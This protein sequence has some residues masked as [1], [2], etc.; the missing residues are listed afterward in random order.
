[1]VGGLAFSQRVTL[2][3]TP[4]FYTYVDALQRRLG[5][6]RVP[7]VAPAAAPVPAD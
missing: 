2:Y 6:V 1:V 4:L 7:R 3:V 5:H